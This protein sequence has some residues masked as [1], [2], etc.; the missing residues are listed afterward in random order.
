MQ[1]FVAGDTSKS[2]EFFKRYVQ[3]VGDSYGA[4][5]GLETLAEFGVLCRYANGTCACTADPVLLTCHSDER[6]GCDCN[7]ICT[8]CD[9]FYKIAGYAQTA[10]YDEVYVRTDT[11]Q[12]FP[13]AV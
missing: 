4:G 3:I 7:S 9:S 13:C 8:H 6:C 5:F 10:G 2:L 12:V 11:V 1:I